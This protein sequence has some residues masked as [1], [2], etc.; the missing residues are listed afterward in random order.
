MSPRKTV[1]EL[2]GAHAVILHRDH[3]TVP[4]LT[5]Q[6]AAIGLK[7]TQ[8]WP[9][10]DASALAADFVFFDADLGHDE[11]FPWARGASPMP[12][13]ALIGSEAPGR[14]EWALAAGA[15]AQ[16]IKP[17][18]GS[19]AYSALLVARATYDVRRALAAEVE[20]L[21]HR[22]NE[23]QTVVRAVNYLMSNGADENTAYEKLRRLA[24]DWRISFEEAAQRVVAKF[25]KDGA[26]DDRRNH[27]G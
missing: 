17:I 21:Q 16:L 13:I 2:G 19:G 7:V 23:R 15:D 5:R 22:L 9:T 3:T 6:L 20:S 25:T 18:G 12:L 27:N 4:T 10:L 24:M 11:Q 1:R 14:I 26:H 8:Q